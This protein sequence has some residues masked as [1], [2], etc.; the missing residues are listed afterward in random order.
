[1]QNPRLASRYA[2]SLLDLAQEQNQLDSVLQDMQLIQSATAGTPELAQLMRSPIVNA[3]KKNTVLKAI[4]EGKVQPLSI[5]F[6]HLLTSK[7]REKVLLEIT[8]SFI[9][10]YKELKRIRVAKLITATPANDQLK[11][12]LQAKAEAALPGYTVE[13]QTEVDP[14][15]I[16]GFILEVGDKMIDASVRRDLSEVRKQ[17]KDNLYISQVLSN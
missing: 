11:Q 14:S 9:S 1:M 6:I 13:F 10:Q 8:A 5:A 2:K 4:F 15:I 3:E 12:T 16:G 17:F 7:G